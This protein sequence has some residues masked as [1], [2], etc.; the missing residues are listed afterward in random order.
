MAVFANQA[1]TPVDK[2]VLL[3]ETPD[4]AR[5]DELVGRIGG[6]RWISR[7]L[8]EPVGALNPGDGHQQFFEAWDAARHAALV[9]RAG[10]IG[11]GPALVERFGPY[12]A[13]V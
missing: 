7:M 10:Q 11:I 5:A 8:H 1:A 4:L 12:Q 2:H 13:P 6:S 3:A 9:E